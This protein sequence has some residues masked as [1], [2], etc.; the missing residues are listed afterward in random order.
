MRAAPNATAMIDFL[1]TAFSSPNT[2]QLRKT[3]L[4]PKRPPSGGLLFRRLRHRRIDQRHVLNVLDR[5]I[6]AVRDV[7][8][9]Q[10]G[11]N[12]GCGGQLGR[13]RP[14]HSAAWLFIRQ[15]PHKPWI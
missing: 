7:E 1:D 9:V 5:D 8:L 11:H 2:P 10:R 15:L 14:P 13:R 3:R 6:Y 4:V 12:S